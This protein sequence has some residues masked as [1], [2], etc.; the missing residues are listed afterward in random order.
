M[1]LF[2]CILSIIGFAVLLVGVGF[3]LILYWGKNNP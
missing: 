2:Q 3:A 1:T